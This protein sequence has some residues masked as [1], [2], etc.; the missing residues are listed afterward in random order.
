MLREKRA[1]LAEEARKTGKPPQIVEKMVDG[2]LRKFY[3]EVVLCEQA[4]VLNPD[5][6]VG[7]ALADAADS[8]GAAIAVGAFVRFR[9]GEGIKKMD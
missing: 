8:A 6:T 2:R 1:V 9:T 5:Q 4:F 7:Q 3:A